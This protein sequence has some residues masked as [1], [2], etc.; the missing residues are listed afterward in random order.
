MSQNYT[1]KLPEIAPPV[2]DD[3]DAGTA[4]IGAISLLADMVAENKR[5]ALRSPL[6]GDKYLGGPGPAYDA[7]TPIGKELGLPRYPPEPWPQYHRR[8]FRVWDDMPFAGDESVLVAQLAATGFPGALIYTPHEW[9]TE[10]GPAGETPY[11]SQFWI[12]FHN[13]ED[14]GAAPAPL[15]DDFDWGDGTLFGIT[16]LSYLTVKTLRGIVNQ[17]KPAHWICRGIIFTFGGWLIGDTRTMSEL[18]G[19]GLTIGA[20]NAT[21]GI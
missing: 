15:Y 1:V 16:G 19:L 20:T 12:V 13:G 3:D 21:I 5:H 4:F 6:V 11:W 9:P 7:L 10:P 8:L 18:D 2:F 14:Y 17:F